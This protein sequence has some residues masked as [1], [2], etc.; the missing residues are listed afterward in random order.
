MKKAKYYLL[1]VA[2]LIT[3]FTLPARAESTEDIIS[4]YEEILPDGSVDISNSEELSRAVGFERLFSEISSA[5]KEQGSEL[6]SLFFSLFAITLLSSLCT[7]FGS[8]PYFKEYSDTLTAACAAV[9]G[10]FVFERLNSLIGTVSEAID[11][12]SAFFSALLPIATAL[13][14]SGGGTAT[15]AAQ[16]SG[17]SLTL[18]IVG[19]VASKLLLPLVSVIFA[20]SLITVLSSDGA[21]SAVLRTVKSVFGWVLGVLSFLLGTSLS[22]Q[23]VIASASDSVTMRAAKYAASSIPVVGSTVSSS[24]STLASGLSFAKSAVGVSAVSVI[25]GITLTPLVRLALFRM[26]F[27][28]CSSLAAM[29]SSPISA[30]L[31]TLKSAL[32]ALIGVFVFCGV[33]YTFQVILF[34]KCGVALL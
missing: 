28:V 5:L 8:S 6:S 7:Y 26:S 20:L 27:D 31:S 15:A 32:D 17:M 9:C 4:D 21:V 19:G 1:I 33:V 3:V 30:Y 18:G 10:A 25:F 14:A 2:V 12:L 29:M 16:A 13:T 22:L 34:M 24:L 23:T 11:E